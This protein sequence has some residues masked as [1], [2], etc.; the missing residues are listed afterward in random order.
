MI[1]K[2]LISVR[3]TAYHRVVLHFKEE[4][5]TVIICKITPD[6]GGLPDVAF[7]VGKR[8]NSLPEARTAVV[9]SMRDKDNLNTDFL[10][11]DPNS[12]VECMVQLDNYLLDNDKD[13]DVLSNETKIETFVKRSFSGEQRVDYL[14]A[15]LVLLDK[16]P[17]E[18][19]LGTINW[20]TAT[21][22]K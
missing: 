1:R 14:V 5:D 16:V 19:V 9:N 6:V 7:L 3:R 4:N 11:I 8:F 22:K 21:V 2:K 17:F 10:T 15:K 12:W 13:F 20:D 18:F